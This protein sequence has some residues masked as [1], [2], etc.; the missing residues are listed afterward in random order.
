M[1]NA[2][3]ARV[4]ALCGCVARVAR[5]VVLLWDNCVAIVELEKPLRTQNAAAGHA[6]I[7]KLTV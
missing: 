3:L 2:I 1:I 4:R 5:S 6:G 7:S